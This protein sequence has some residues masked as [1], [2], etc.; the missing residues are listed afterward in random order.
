M[1]PPEAARVYLVDDHPLVREWLANLI[2][3]QPDLSVCGEAESAVAALPG[4][5]DACPDIAVVDISLDGCSGLDLIRDIRQIHP[6]LPILVLSMHAEELYAE[7]SLRAG[8]RG[9]VMKREATK[10]VV[11][12][13][14]GV[15]QGRIYLSQRMEAALAG[16]IEI[17]ATADPGSAVSHLSDRELEVFQRLGEGWDSRRIADELHISIKTVQTYA[18][19]IREKLCISTASELIREAIRWH[20]RHTP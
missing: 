7:R 9:Y 18:T 1:S 2:A 8:A 20:E 10:Q 6:N 16:K 19:R 11:L 3:R 4:I 5:H 17:H 14:R 12:A 15:L 13:I